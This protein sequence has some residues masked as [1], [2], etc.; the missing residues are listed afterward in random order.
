MLFGRT[1]WTK[2]ADN[3]LPF[4]GET[5]CF[6]D[7]TSSS[8][9]SELPVASPFSIPNETDNGVAL[10]VYRLHKSNAVLVATVDL[11]L[12]SDFAK[13]KDERYPVRSVVDRAVVGELRLSV[14]FQE[15]QTLPIRRYRVIEVSSG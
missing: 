15:V 4:W 6:N 11:P 10:H 14:T 13:I 5:L 8:S 3:A 12:V 1:G 9:C 2:A 7:L